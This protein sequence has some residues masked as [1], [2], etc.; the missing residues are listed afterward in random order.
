MFGYRIPCLIKLGP[1][2]ADLGDGKSG[3]ASPVGLQWLAVSKQTR[4]TTQPREADGNP[5]VWGLHTKQGDAA[6]VLLVSLSLGNNFWAH[7]SVQCLLQCLAN[8]A[9]LINHGPK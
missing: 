2:E 1:L 4:C 9:L 7:G 3:A 8:K 5:A 6:G